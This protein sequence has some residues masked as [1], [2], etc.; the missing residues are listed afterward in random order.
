MPPLHGIV[1]LCWQR[2]LGRLSSRAR[3]R[4]RFISRCV[5]RFCG[6]GTCGRLRIVD[7]QSAV[8]IDPQREA[9]TDEIMEHVSEG[10]HGAGEG[11]GR[12]GNVL[13]LELVLDPAAPVGLGGGRTNDE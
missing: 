8:L 11:M 2:I 1:K 12:W 3:L 10:D 4:G 9:A 6:L 13:L 5:F 7:E